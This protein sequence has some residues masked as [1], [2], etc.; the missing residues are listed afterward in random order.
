MATA[1]SGIKVLD[2]TGMGPSSFAAGMLG[3][4][5]AD[6]I[7]I[8]T[9]PGASDKGVGA[10]IEFI[11]GIDAPAFF[12]SPRNKKNIGI[13][14]KAESGKKLFHQLAETA[15]VVIESFRPGVMDRLGI[16]Y[17]TVSKE[18][19]RI[20]HCSVSGFGQ[21]G[22]YRDL[23]GH[24]A[25]YAAMGGA[26]GLVGH[27]EDSPP[28]M[29]ENILADMTTAVLQAVIGIQTAIIAREKTGRGQLVDISM[30]DG[31][32]FMLSCTPEI[33]EYLMNGTVPQRG[34]TLFSGSQPCYAVYETTD[35]KY[36]TIGTL[37]PHF[38]K[39]LCHTLDREDLI[40][41]QYASSPDKEEVFAELKNIFLTKTR[42]EWFAIL[43][44]A[45]VPVG[46]VLNIHEAFSDP[47]MQHR[48]MLIEVDHPRW[49]KV[50]QIGFPI[51]FSDTPWQLR[52]PAAR[53]GDHTDEVLSELG[54]TPEEID[55]LRQER[56]IC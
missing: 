30:T 54:Y 52:I 51:K 36:L 17:E 1:L 44:K 23:P 4:M 14:F 29:V 10:G 48:E 50:K 19:P 43:T 46:K 32:L 20:I 9:P 34:N 11:E 22:P 28:V 2:L 42:D 37:E 53:L 45:D 7:K 8:S 18:N 38:W 6:V 25:N 16:G 56:I 26:L 47:H 5:G 3:D 39:K 12:D 49:G 41:K 35:H 13:N 15:D 21:D 40:V 24:D 33:G 55:R 31:V 27:S